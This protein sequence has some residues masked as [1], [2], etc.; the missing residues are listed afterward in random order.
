MLGPVYSDIDGT[1]ILGAVITNIS[2][3][4]VTFSDNHGF[5]TWE[6]TNGD[7]EMVVIALGYDKK[8][9][10]IPA[11]KTDFI[12]VKLYKQSSSYNDTSFLSLLNKQYLLNPAQRLDVKQIQNMAML[13]SITDIQKSLQYLLVLERLR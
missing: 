8:E 2:Q 3:T 7:N 11:N 6:Q 12:Y 4:Y 5:F 9:L 1:P 10:S 13:G